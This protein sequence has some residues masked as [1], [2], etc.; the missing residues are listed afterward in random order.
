[1]AAALIY[2][3][4][5]RV[6]RY[7]F[8][9]QARALSV[10]AT[11]F[12]HPRTRF[13]YAWTTVAVQE[14]NVVGLI[15]AAPTPTL[16]RTALPTAWI[17]T[18]TLGVRDMA[19]FVWRSLWLLGL[20][21]S[22]PDDYYVAHLAVDPVYRRRGIGRLL[23]RHAEATARR[24]GHPRVALTVEMDNTPALAFYERLG[25]RI[26][27]ARPTPRLKRRFGFPGLYR[28]EKDLTVETPS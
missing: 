9:S 4:M 27:H 16:H 10:L 5:S 3:A 24:H 8:H 11:L 28:M 23:L 1:M 19:G 21:L 22:R 7:L 17:L 13:S 14:G 2:A 20:D 26:A 6:A 18:R 25:Y 15:L 12:R